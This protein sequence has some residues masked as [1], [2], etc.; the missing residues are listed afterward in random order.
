MNLR[1]RISKSSRIGTVYY[2]IYALG[3]FATLDKLVFP[4][5]QKRLINRDEVAQLTSYF[6]LDFGYINDPSAFIHLKIDEQ[7]KRIYFLEEYVRKG[8]LN[9]KIAEAIKDL[10]YSKKS[11]PL[12]RLRKNQ[13]LR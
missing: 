13:L 6:G 4:T 8:L 5:Y 7:N 9:D 10:G 11:L 2:K 1:S 12:T 3:E